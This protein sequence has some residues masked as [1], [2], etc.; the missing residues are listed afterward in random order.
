LLDWCPPDL[1]ADLLAYG[2]QSWPDV[3]RML[4]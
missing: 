3:E 1:T 4:A 2:R